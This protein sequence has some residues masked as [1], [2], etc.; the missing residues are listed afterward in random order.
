MA[1][2]Q[3]RIVPAKTATQQALDIIAFLTL[4]AY[5]LF[6]L[7]QWPGLPEQVPLHFNLAGEVDSYGSKYS[8]M[9][10]PLIA[11][12]NFFL[13]NFLNKRPYT[14]NYPSTITEEN[15]EQQYRSAMNLM[16]AINAG[17]IILLFYISWEVVNIANNGST[18]RGG[19]FLAVLLGVI[20][21]PIV[22]YLVKSGQK[23]K[24]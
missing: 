23:Q 10:L 12:G 3:P 18:G 1:K 24:S 5:I 19:Y 15:A 22:L 16:S 4:V 14:F 6:F 20:F 21:L 11:I 13:F 2:D 9:L 17:V 8:M 7:L